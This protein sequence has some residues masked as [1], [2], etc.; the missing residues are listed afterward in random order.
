MNKK[1]FTL[2]ELLATIVLLGVIAGIVVITVNTG[3]GNAKKKTEEIF[4]STLQD[5]LDVYL[6]TDARQLSGKNDV[7][8]VKKTHGNVRIYLIGTVSFN[9]VINS[10]MSPLN[11]DDFVNPAKEDGTCNT[12]SNLE[13]AIIEIYRDADYVY[14]Y[15]FE[16]GELDN[17]F[18]KDG[19]V[20]NL[21]EIVSEN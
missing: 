2:V 3:F 17:C 12:T 19:V 21:P 9:D 7:G 1:G 15:K 6:D 20:T 10:S 11:E 14:Y 13:N 5:A 16:K 18:L 4:V 8:Y